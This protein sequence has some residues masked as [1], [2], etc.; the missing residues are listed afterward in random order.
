M[1]LQDKLFKLSKTALSG[2]NDNLILKIINKILKKQGKPKNKFLLISSIGPNS[3]HKNCNWHQKLN[4]DTFFIYYSD[5]F[6]SNE[7]DFYLRFSGKK[8]VQY[9]YLFQQY[10]FIDKYKYIFILDND[11]LISGKN[12]SKLFKIAD[13]LDVNLLAPSIKIKD[14]KHSEVLKLVNFYNNFNP[15]KGFKNFL[16]FKDFLPKNLK[17]IYNHVIK[18]TYWPHMI[19]TKNVKDR[20]IKETNI[21]EDGRTIINISL[22]KKFR[23]DIKFMKLF[24]SGI[25]FDHI[26]ANYSNFKKIYVVDFINYIHLDPYKDKNKEYIELKIIQKYIKKYNIPFKKIYYDLIEEKYYKLEKKNTTN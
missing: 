1:D 14:I 3:V 23:K 20:Y 5:Y 15:K 18:Y 16:F 2:K 7:S 19:Q 17:K 4:Y 21:V 11:N 6:K 22:I 25:L 10:D 8:L 24:R 9:F 13:K 12:I 26:L